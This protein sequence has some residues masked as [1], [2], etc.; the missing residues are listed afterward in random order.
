MGLLS[1]LKLRKIEKN[2]RPEKL[3]SYQREVSAV[4][5]EQT[6]PWTA[7][8][9]NQNPELR[10]AENLSRLYPAD[11]EKYPVLAALV[12]QLSDVKGS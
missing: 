7:A 3:N 10:T 5:A 8:E 2:T 1:Y 4:A 9:L 12:S 6:R 11:L